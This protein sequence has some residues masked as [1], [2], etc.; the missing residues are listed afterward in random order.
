MRVCACYIEF[1]RDIMNLQCYNEFVLKSEKNTGLCVPNY[2]WAG[3]V[4][5]VRVIL[6]LCGLC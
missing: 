6:K 5:I 4:K 1:E 2:T 3:Y